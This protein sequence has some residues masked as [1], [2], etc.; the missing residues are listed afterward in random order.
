MQS[1][2]HNQSVSHT[3]CWMRWWA[4]WW[5]ARGTS[6]AV[7]AWMCPGT[8]VFVAEINHFLINLIHHELNTF[9]LRFIAVVYGF[10]NPTMRRIIIVITFY[11]YVVVNLPAWWRY[12]GKQVYSGEGHGGPQLGL[13]HVCVIQ[14]HRRDTITSVWYFVSQDRYKVSRLRDSI[15]E[16]WYFI[17]FKCSKFETK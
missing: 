7:C 14:S 9:I 12:T 17:Y 8:H 15:M 6:T 16:T 3:I 5:C 4:R 11:H 13:N 10:T 2:P 1:N